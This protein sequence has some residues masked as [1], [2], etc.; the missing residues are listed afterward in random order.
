VPGPVCY[1]NVG[2]QPTITDANLALGRLPPALIGGG[3]ALSVERARS[4]LTTLAQRLGEKLSVEQLAEGIVEIANWNQANAIR[5]MTIQKG[6][7][8]RR[9]ALLSFGGS[10]PAQSPAVARLLGMKCC[11]VPPHPGNVSAFGLLAVDWRTDHVATRVTHED[12]VVLSM[13]S[14]IFSQLETEAMQTLERDGIDK[15]R[16]RLAREADLRYVGQSMEVRVSAPPGA[17]DGGYV[18]KLTANFHSAHRRA[19]GYDY[20]G[21]QKVELVN[22]RVSG[23]GLIEHARL[24]KLPSVENVVPA[25]KA[26]RRVYFDGA[27]VET[28]VY[29]RAALPP[30]CRIEGP[31]VIEEFGS[32][33]VVFPGQFVEVDSHGILIV[34]EKVSALEGKR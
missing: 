26:A 21:R 9:F 30:G 28:A 33:T 1:P 27:W 13:L 8:P 19:F 32:T 17:I 29:E 12:A 7:D 16:V 2:E 24:P 4:G 11:L 3:I 25:K 14:G 6:I 15:S 20:E 31:A 5:Q 22:F 18:T 34:R 23:F 10:G